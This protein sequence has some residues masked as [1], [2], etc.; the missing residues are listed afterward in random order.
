MAHLDGGDVRAAHADLRRC[1]WLATGR[2]LALYAAVARVNLAC[3][4]VLAGDLPAALGGFGAARADYERLAPGRLPALAVERARALLAAGLLD[5]ADRE[6]GDALEGAARQRLS[7]VH[8]T[9]CRCARRWRCSAA[10]R[11]RSV[12]T[13]GRRP[14]PRAA[15]RTP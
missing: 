15:Q 14:V 2:D 9:P 5:D 4:D 10:G 3:L 7:Q 11:R 12:G 8:P 1:V 13:G 6:L